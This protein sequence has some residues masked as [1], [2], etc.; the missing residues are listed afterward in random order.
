[1]IWMLN[2]DY[3]YWQNNRKTKRYSNT[4]KDNR[5]DLVVIEQVENDAN[6]MIIDK[7]NSKIPDLE[8]RIEAAE[9]N[10]II[11]VI[12]AMDY[13][14]TRIE[15]EIQKIRKT[16]EA[17]NVAILS[18]LMR[19]K[20]EN[21]KTNINIQKEP[22]INILK[23]KHKE[24]IRLMLCSTVSYDEIREKLGVGKSSPRVYV[25]ELQKLGFPICKQEFDGKVLVSFGSNEQAMAVA[26]KFGYTE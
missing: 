6:E 3:W 24:L 25:S 11:P 7:I 10:I 22:Q 18:E 5:N 17:G 20:D 4:S 15:L 13:S 1:M 2:W 14:N 12:T 9:E 21:E 26:K 8:E 23:E 19:P 16:I